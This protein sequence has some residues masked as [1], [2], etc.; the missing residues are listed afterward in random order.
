MDEMSTLTMQDLCITLTAVS[1]AHAKRMQ[2]PWNAFDNVNLMGLGVAGG[3]GF[4]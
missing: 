2:H 1:K 3:H 4:G